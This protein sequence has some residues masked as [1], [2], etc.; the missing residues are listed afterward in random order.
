MTWT[1]TYSPV[2]GSLLFS[3]LVSA[4]PIIVLLGMIVKHCKAHWAALAGL[5]TS[6]AVAV[7]V[8]G[9]PIPLIG[10]AAVHGLAYGLFPIGWIV[11]GALFL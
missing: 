5:A 2:A 7:L 4:L 1:Q 3:A 8:F 6:M 9:M 10:M 11:V